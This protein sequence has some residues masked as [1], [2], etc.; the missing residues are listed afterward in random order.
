MAASDIVVL[1]RNGEVSQVTCTKNVMASPDDDLPPS[2]PAGNDLALPALAA[3]IQ[4]QQVQT[5][6][7]VQLMSGGQQVQTSLVPFT[8]YTATDPGKQEQRGQGSASSDVHDGGDPSALTDPNMESVEV[9]EEEEDHSE[10]FLSFQGEVIVQPSIDIASLQGQAAVPVPFQEPEKSPRSP[11]SPGSRSPVVSVPTTQAQHSGAPDTSP[12]HSSQP[13]T[14]SETSPD[15]EEISSEGFSTADFYIDESMPSSMTES[16][17]YKKI[18]ELQALLNDRCALLE[19]KEK[20]L[21]SSREE[22][23]EVRIL[24]GI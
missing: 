12:A 24:L 22:L 11:H 13:R 3:P 18:Q 20:Q 9:L 10:E 14:T 7:Q 15:I 6:Q 23:D 16:P 2:G 17:P 1:D 5:D 8:T 19:N 21:T 4:G